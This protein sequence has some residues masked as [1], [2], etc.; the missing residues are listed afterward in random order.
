MTTQP[1]NNPLKEAYNDLSN[2]INDLN[3][4]ITFQNIKTVVKIYTFLF[5]ACSFGYFAGWAG[6]A[7][8]GGTIA[9]IFSLPFALI[10]GYAIGAYLGRHLG[11]QTSQFILKITDVFAKKITSYDPDIQ[12]AFGRI[13]FIKLSW[14]PETFSKIKFDSFDVVEKRYNAI[15]KDKS[16]FSWYKSKSA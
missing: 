12:K 15:L 9:P 16:W 4:S 7:L 13:N 6:N 8:I 5:A 3:K 1:I 11:K 14:F 2:T 10:G